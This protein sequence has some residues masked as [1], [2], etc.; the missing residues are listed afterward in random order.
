MRPLTTC[1]LRFA[2]LVCALVV[3]VGATPAAAGSHDV[4][5]FVRWNGTDHDVRSIYADGSG[6]EAVLVGAQDI[7]DVRASPGQTLFVGT[8]RTGGD[9]DLIVAELD[10]THL[11][12]LT[13]TAHDDRWPAWSPDGRTL[14]FVRSSPTGTRLMTIASDGDGPAQVIWGGIEAIAPVW[15]PDGVS[16]G[17]TMMEPTSVPGYTV[18]PQAY[19]VP[20]DA[21]AAPARILK[22]HFGCYLG[23][24]LSDGRLVVV[25]S[26]ATGYGV[27]VASPG[28]GDWDRIARQRVSFDFVPVLTQSELIIYT[29]MPN[30]GHDLE[31]SAVHPDGTGHRQLTANGAEDHTVPV[32]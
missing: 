10:G 14:V 8:D 3:V 31:L 22:A 28:G 30:G 21:S 2:A 12:R 13:A 27:Y 15:S 7:D 17:F 16:I 26:T 32:S 23:G 9:G 20:A 6:P 4:V 18:L 19:A 5:V 1:R 24:W 11:R 25:R 29:S